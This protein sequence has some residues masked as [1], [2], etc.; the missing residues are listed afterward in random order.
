M[1][2]SPDGAL[3]ALPQLLRVDP[4]LPLVLG[5]ADATL[6]VAGPAQPVLLAALAHFTERSPLLVVTATE[7]DAVRLADDLACFL[8]HHGGDDGAGA[9]VGPIE[10]PVVVLPAWETLPFERVSPEVET[11]GRRLAVLWGLTHEHD[12]AAVGQAPRIIVAPIRALLQRLGPYRDSAPPIVIRPGQQLA[13]DEVIGQLV[14]SGYRR[15]HQVEHRGELAVRG[16]I[17]DVFPSTADVPVR[18]DLWGDEVDRLTAFAVNDQRS[19]FDLEAAVL[20]GCRE[21]I[22]TDAVR[23]AAS[24]LLRSQPWGATQWGRLAEGRVLRRHGIVAALHPSRRGGA[25]RPV[26]PGLPGGAGRTA[27]HPGPGG[28]AARRRGGAGRG[29]GQDLGRRGPVRAGFPPPA[30]A[31]RAAAG[32]SPRPVSWPCR[33][34]PRARPRRR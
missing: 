11:M 34:H 13:A 21:V 23:S 15:E 8:P 24:A 30:P 29:P 16:G 27:T 9:T 10:G 3:S 31:V 33:R 19:S 25:A 7:V 14:G 1:T 22:P 5:S 20:F 32:R 28:P 18:I 2:D 4:A 26:T 12:A 6:A 17:I